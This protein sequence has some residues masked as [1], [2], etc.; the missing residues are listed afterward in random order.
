MAKQ[1]YLDYAAATPL[2]PKVLLAMQPYFSNQFYN[3]SATYEPA[4]EV[5]KA[6]LNA[7]KTVAHWL[8]ARSS[9]IIFTAGGTE[10][11][12]L[13]IHGILRQYPAANIVVSG[14]EHE[15]VLKPA[16]NYN[17]RVVKLKPDGRIDLDDLHKQ[18]TEQ[19]VLV[20][21]MQAN[22]EIGTIQPLR[23]IASLINKQRQKRRAKPQALPLYF[24][25]DA[26]QAANYL[27]LHVARLGVDMMTINGGKIYGPKQSGALYVK[28][29]IKLR[30]LVQ[31]GGQE[32]GQRSGTENVAAIIGLAVALNQTQTIRHQEAARLSQLQQACWTRIAADLPTAA[33]NGSIKYRLPNNIHLTLAGQDNERLL[34][35]LDERGILAA[36]GSACSASEQIPS[37]V[38]RA[39]GLS[40]SAARASLR[41]SMGRGTTKSMIDQCLNVLKQLA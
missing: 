22:N 9:E 4:R 18:L 13:A 30:P 32:R 25:T 23:E 12:N 40:D 2:D 15:S 3:P 35:E 14:I 1:I 17:Y 27:D 26:A 41:L 29:G 6:L 19:T 7:R 11:N 24:H 38:L 34:I 21:V 5:Q 31:G 8:G 37:H 20:S 36:A 10:A 28:A 33:V 39:I 16:E